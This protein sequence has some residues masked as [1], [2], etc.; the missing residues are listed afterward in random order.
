MANAKK[1]KSGKWT[2]LVYS[3]TKQINGKEKRF[4]KRFTAESKRE[5][6]RLAKEYEITL[7][8]KADHIHDD[9]TVKQAVQNYINIKSN[10]LS[11]NTVRVYKGI[12]NNSF[13]LIGNIK[14]SKI[15]NTQIQKELNEE[16]K[17]LSPKS[18]K[19]TYG[20]LS[21]AMALYS[22][23]FRIVLHYPEKRNK[24]IKIPSKNDI[25]R[26]IDM[27]DDPQLNISIKI[28]A[29]MGLRRGEI[30][31]L[32]IKDV[33]LKKRLLFVRRSI[34]ISETGEN[35]EKSTKTK[36][37]NRVLQIPEIILPDFVSAM[38]GKS[39]EDSLLGISPSK[40]SNRFTRL[41]SKVGVQH[42]TFH[43]LRHYYASILL[44]NN[45]PDKYAMERMGH[46]TNGL[47]KQVYQHTMEEKEKEISA[48]VEEYLNRNFA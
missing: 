46:A 12:L 37:G 25:Q 26:I 38:F 6:E 45:V 13:P 36:A 48:Q 35:I 15:N 41:V 17:K 7:K 33:D 5:A 1:T 3:H 27:C 2:C 19:N 34:A 47:L 4:Y 43:S 8:N 40:I 16:S 32:K 28:A 10:V 23:E 30:A 42:F 31:A 20:L 18:I 39:D 29:F 44:A 24:E 14:L 9:M 21:A 22:P 11:P